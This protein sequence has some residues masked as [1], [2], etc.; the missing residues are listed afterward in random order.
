[1][2]DEGDYYDEVSDPC[3]WEVR[4]YRLLAYTDTDNT[5]TTWSIKAVYRAVTPNA[6]E[7]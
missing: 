5:T 4:L 3:W 1:M 6:R 7:Q 2:N